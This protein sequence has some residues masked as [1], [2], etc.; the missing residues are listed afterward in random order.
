MDL[1]RG[2]LSVG[3]RVRRAAA[4]AGVLP[5]DPMGPVV[6]ALA[7]LPGEV[8]LRIAPV[9]AQMQAAR[10]AIEQAARRPA[11]TDDQVRYQVVPKLLAAWGAWQ[12]LAGVVLALAA[13]GVGFGVH[14]WLTPSLTCEDAR[15]GHV[16]FVWTQP[17]SEP[18]EVAQAP[19]QQTKKKP[20]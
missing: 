7:D 4:E 10:A 13:F 18:A 3:D 8:E 12:T 16:C 11:L 14:W 15:G 1:E 20:Q 5:S 17:A 9:L 2:T 6:E 19:A